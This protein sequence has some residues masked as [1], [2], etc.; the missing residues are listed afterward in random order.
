MNRNMIRSLV[1]LLIA[2]TTLAVG[3][4]ADSLANPR[5]TSDTK[6][7]AGRERPGVKFDCLPREVKSDQVVTFGRTAKEKVTVEQTLIQMKARCRNGKLVDAKNKEIRF[8]R[9]SCWG[10]PPPDYLKIEERENQ[11]LEKLKRQ[12]TVIVLHCNPRIA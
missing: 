7:V 8:F 4:K 12:Y 1:I 5:A 11:E 2:G 3:P 10:H 9:V 6:P